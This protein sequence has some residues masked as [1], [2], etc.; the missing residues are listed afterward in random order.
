MVLKED[1]ETAEKLNGFL[2]SVFITE[3]IGQILEPLSI[4]LW[5]E[6]DQ[7]KPMKEI[8]QFRTF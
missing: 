1:L 3:D 6:L 8:R 4:F 2:A 7:L 5:L